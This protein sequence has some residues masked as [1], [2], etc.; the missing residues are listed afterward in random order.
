[1][2]LRVVVGLETCSDLQNALVC[3]FPI[4]FSLCV[5]VCVCACLSCS[6]TG[7]HV[8]GIRKQR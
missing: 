6:R 3:I 8:A 1:M 4:S 2:G 5:C 7:L